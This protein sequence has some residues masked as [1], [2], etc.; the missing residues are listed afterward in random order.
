MKADAKP[1]DQPRKDTD[2]RLGRLKEKLESVLGPGGEKRDDKNRDTP[3]GSASEQ[4]MLEKKQEQLAKKTKPKAGSES[5]L[6]Q[7]LAAKAEAS[8]SGSSK[9][10]TL[11]PS[12]PS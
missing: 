9:S 12:C 8:G 5:T 4:E 1:G 2:A 7:K 3:G 6:L 11:L 10:K